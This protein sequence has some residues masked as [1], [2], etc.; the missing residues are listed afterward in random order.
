MEIPIN[1]PKAEES[2]AGSYN[3]YY[4]IT[5]CPRCHVYFIIFP[6]I[7]S[8]VCRYCS[9]K[10][11]VRFRRKSRRTR[12]T[13]IYSTVEEAMTNTILMNWRQEKMT[14]DKSDLGDVGYSLTTGSSGPK[15]MDIAFVDESQE[16][17]YEEET[18]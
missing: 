5:R 4:A 12:I 14:I 8:T 1:P 18:Y 9:Y 2:R 10:F 15:G 16:D 13:G 7:R 6:Y 11:K 3:T 17:N